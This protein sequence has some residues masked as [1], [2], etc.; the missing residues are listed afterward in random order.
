MDRNQRASEI[1]SQYVTSFREYFNVYMEARKQ[2]PYEEMMDFR[3]F[4]FRLGLL[5]EIW[6][7]VEKKQKEKYHG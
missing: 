6:V 1:S 3:R 7:T 5:A 2:H 4:M